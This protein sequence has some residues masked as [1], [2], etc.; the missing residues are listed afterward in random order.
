MH[1]NDMLIDITPVIYN[2]TPYS[3]FRAEMSTGAKIGTISKM[4]IA[5]IEASKINC[6]F[7][8]ID[9]AKWSMTSMFEKEMRHIP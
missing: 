8:V 3:C 5:W 9:V 6:S 2:M 1:T 7:S 4:Y